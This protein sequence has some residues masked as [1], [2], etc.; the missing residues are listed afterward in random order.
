MVI[1]GIELMTYWLPALS[2]RGDV[3]AVRPLLIGGHKERLLRDT[4]SAN[5][6]GNDM[7]AMSR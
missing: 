3:G 6:E 7:E 1:F 4:L 5:P 2:A